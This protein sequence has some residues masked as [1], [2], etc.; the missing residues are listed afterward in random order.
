[1][2]CIIVPD[3]ELA[4]WED[5]Y[6]S[7]ITFL[8]L[9]YQ[10]EFLK[11]GGSVTSTGRIDGASFYHIMKKFN[12]TLFKTANRGLPGV[13]DFNKRV[14]INANVAFSPFHD[15]MHPRGDENFPNISYCIRTQVPE[16]FEI[17][18]QRI[19]L[20]YPLLLDYTNVKEEL[21]KDKKYLYTYQFGEWMSVP[22]KST[23]SKRYETQ[24]IK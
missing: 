8:P 15:I 18:L 10:K 23:F 22:E 1:M 21:L 4:T 17:R 20:W 9:A 6:N 14:D 7:D 3:G 12:P 11:Q 5:I 13:S 19:F 2:R 24:V 16:P